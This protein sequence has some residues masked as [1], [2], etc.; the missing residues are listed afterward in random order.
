MTMKT[1]SAETAP[2]AASPDEAPRATAW[3][4]MGDDASL[5]PSFPPANRH[6]ASPET[7]SAESL[8][9]SIPPQS[10]GVEG[11]GQ[12]TDEHV[13]DPTDIDG[14]KGTYGLIKSPDGE[15][16][17]YKVKAR[18]SG[19]NLPDNII[20]TRLAQNAGEQ[21]SA[22]AGMSYQD[23]GRQ[24]IAGATERA[25][26]GSKELFGRAGAGIKRIAGKLV[27]L[28]R[29]GVKTVGETAGKGASVVVGFAAIE[30]P[31][32]AKATA[33]TVSEAREKSAQKISEL[34]EN[35]RNRRKERRDK[36]KAA[37]DER[38]RKYG[39]R[40]SARKDALKEMTQQAE[41]SR[42][43]S[44]ERQGN[45]HDKQN[46]LL[47]VEVAMEQQLL[48]AKAARA[49]ASQASRRYTEIVRHRQAAEAVYRQA[50]K[51]AKE[52]PEDSYHQSAAKQAEDEY[53]AS[54]QL[55]RSAFNDYIVFQRASDAISGDTDRLQ[56]RAYELQSD[57][58]A[59]QYDEELGS[60]DRLTVGVKS[61]FTRV[62]EFVDGSTAAHGL[63][64]RAG[65]AIRRKLQGSGN[66]QEAKTTA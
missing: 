35:A 37:K 8:P 60:R 27:R 10:G 39:E 65:Q 33:E 9:P 12:N 48:R 23:R 16:I 59:L 17:P 43:Q 40:Q 52:H 44:N 62:A 36:R 22:D 18:S 21:T 24:I 6:M 7:A 25:K 15:L 56:R 38:E 64:R 19:S 53:F 3:D 14:K 41:D 51:H 29:G 2:M 63:L 4:N 55:E 49:R 28:A 20:N 31:R 61:A 54:M 46:Q 50:A 26:A 11:Q 5:P 32:A 66:R 30:G 1:A 58:T 42:R 13:T 47:D 45:I 34:A 57:I